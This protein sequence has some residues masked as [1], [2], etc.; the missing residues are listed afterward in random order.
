MNNLSKRKIVLGMLM[1]LVLAFSVQGTADA[2][3]LS[4][5]SGDLQTKTVGSSFDITFSVGLTGDTSIY[6]NRNETI[7]DE[8]TPRVIDA[9]GFV[10][11]A[12]IGGV[13]YR[14]ST[15]ANSIQG[16]RYEVLGDT[17]YP[18]SSDPTGDG[19]NWIAANGAHVD[20]NGNVVDSVGRAVYE[21]QA[22]TIGATADPSSAIA[23]SLRFNYNDEA[24]AIGV[25]TAT[26][27]LELASNGYPVTPIPNVID[28]GP[29]RSITADSVNATIASLY[30]MDPVRGLPNFGYFEMCAFSSRNV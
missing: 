14:E 23:D 18:T 6:N 20:S 4:K 28:T 26:I 30:E 15:A 5:T 21:D 17:G 25:S 3:T 29:A 24:I 27:S 9:N 22:F 2:L 7:S 8:A 12:P 19:N 13:R 10:L 16:F 11:T 1:A